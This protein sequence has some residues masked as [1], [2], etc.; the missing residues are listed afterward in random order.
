MW[1]TGGGKEVPLHV[2]SCYVNTSLPDSERHTQ[3]V[4]LVSPDG[5]KV[6]DVKENSF[7]LQTL[8]DKFALVQRAYVDTKIMVPALNS[9]IKDNFGVYNIKIYLDGDLVKKYPY[10][11][12]AR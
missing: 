2:V 11:I 10:P 12:L 8:T 7:E 1:Q 3:K 4:E 5:R 9:A 6:L